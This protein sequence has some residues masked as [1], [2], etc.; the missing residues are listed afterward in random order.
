[1]SAPA[2]D[3]FECPSCRG[4]IEEDWTACPH[5]GLVFD[6]PEAEAKP[7]ASAVVLPAPST[8]TQPAAHAGTAPARSAAPAHPA[9]PVAAHLTGA[10]ADAPALPSVDTGEIPFAPSGGGP[11][12]PITVM[13]E[14]ASPSGGPTVTL[15]SIIS[16]DK[17]DDRIPPEPPS[18]GGRKAVTMIHELA[19]PSPQPAPPAFEPPSTALA[20]TVV[21]VAP[22]LSGTPAR[23]LNEDLAA[24]ERMINAAVAKALRENIAAFSLQQ[25]AAATVVTTAATTATRRKGVLAVG[26]GLFLGGAIGEITALNWDTWIK[27]MADSVIGPIQQLGVIGMATVAGAGAAVVLLQA[28]RSKRRTKT[29]SKRGSARAH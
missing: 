29:R 13:D 2:K 9:P 28:G 26:A 20:P 8:T 5:C 17:A 4:L 12:R 11:K 3:E 15:E 27:G 23:R 14:R 7:T 18:D 21:V 6:P 1:M 19:P 22:E 25:S 24:I 10:T 16:R